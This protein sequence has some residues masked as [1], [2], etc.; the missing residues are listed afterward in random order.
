MTSPAYLTA[1]PDSNR[2]PP[3]IPYIVGNEAAERFSFYGMR[4]ILVVYMTKYLYDANHNPDFMSKD[5]AKFYYHLFLSS[6]YF[7]P[8]IGAVFSDWLWG[9]YRTI[10][11]LSIVY[12][13][14]HLALSVIDGRPGLFAGLILIALGSG[15][16]K[17]CVSAHVGDQFGKSN[18]HLLERVF[19]WFYLA[20]NLGALISSVLTPELLESEWMIKRFGPER[21]HQIAFGVPGVLMLLATIV[22]W[23]GRHKFVHVPPGGAAFFRETFGKE[24]LSVVL[25]L[26]PLYCFAAIFWS[27]YDQTGSSWVLQAE[28]MDRRILWLTFPAQFPW[29]SIGNVE[30]SAAALQAVNPFLILVYVPLFSYVIY[31]AAGPLLSTPLRRIGMGLMLI[32]VSFL[33]CGWLQTRIDAG[34]AVSAYWQM[35]AYLVLTASEV[36][37]SVTCLEFSYTQ[38]PPRMK[39]LVMA[40]NLFSV[41]AGNFLTSGVNALI[42]QPGMQELL[43]GAR[44]YWFFAGLMF[45][46][47]VVFIPFSLLFKPRNYLPPG[48][49]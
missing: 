39:S 3:G 4:A 33:I 36:L 10:L 14:G 29:I 32:A 43:A 37:V 9:K 40:L 21:T 19:G 6:A 49:E 13:I 2:M 5:E 30:V 46:A 20:I 42:S 25:R 7:F 31:P 12:C 44:Y 18:Q 27:L 22:F 35:I 45:T 8:L 17:P 38:A 48:A 34:E 11:W 47:A 23:F 26:I 28:N 16:I 41:S 15:G 1:P 24:G